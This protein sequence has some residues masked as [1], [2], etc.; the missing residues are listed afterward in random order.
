MSGLWC[1][2]RTHNRTRSPRE[3]FDMRSESFLACLCACVLPFSLLLFSHFTFTFTFPLHSLFIDR[4]V[5]TTER[6][7]SASTPKVT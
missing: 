7:Q 5:K 4:D 1:L 6:I 2:A 3:V